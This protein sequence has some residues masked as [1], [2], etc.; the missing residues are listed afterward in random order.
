MQYAIML[1][2][3]AH[4]TAHI[5]TEE[6][7]EKNITDSTHAHLLIDKLARSEC[8]QCELFDD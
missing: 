3:Y 5:H 6:E 8:M 2:A 7:K 1:Y 4:Q